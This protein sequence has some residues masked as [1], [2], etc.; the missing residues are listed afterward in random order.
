MGK[1]FCT[2]CGAPLEENAR[3]CMKCG[4]PCVDQP[5]E[6]APVQSQPGQGS[7]G[8]APDPANPPAMSFFSAPDKI[9]WYRR[10]M[11]RTTGRIN[12]LHFL[13]YTIL[14]LMF[15]LGI[16][17]VFV[18]LVAIFAP[19]VHSE[20]DETVLGLVYSLVCLPFFVAG[21]MTAIR[22][23]HDFNVTGWVVLAMLI[24]RINAIAALVLLLV[25]GTSGPNKYGPDPI[26]GRH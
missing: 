2:N 6:Q 4:T 20:T 3:F 21:Y 22:R 10:N 15:C 17:I 25:S 12:R 8:Y 11:L 1:R 16:F 14:N 5:Q 9:A 24:P 19:E 18:I 13:T 26:T 23:A 7:G